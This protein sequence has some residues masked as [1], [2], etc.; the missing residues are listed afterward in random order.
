MSD[1][2]PEWSFRDVLQSLLDDPTTDFQDAVI[3]LPK[4]RH[5]THDSKLS[6]TALGVL[7]WCK[8]SLCAGADE[9]YEHEEHTKVL[10]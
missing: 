7:E 2:Q 3:I 9:D 10:N 4:M 5:V 6:L 8:A 1:D